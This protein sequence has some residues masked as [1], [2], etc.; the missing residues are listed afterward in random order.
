MEVVALVAHCV[1]DWAKELPVQDSVMSQGKVPE[2][3]KI[4]P[5]Y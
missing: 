5:R 1:K 4:M 2:H 3:C